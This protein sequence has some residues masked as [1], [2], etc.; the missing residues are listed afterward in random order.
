MVK[1]LESKV[2]D[3]VEDAEP[4]PKVDDKP[5]SG[6]KVAE[7]VSQQEEVSLR[8]MKVVKLPIETLVDLLVG[9]TMELVP[10]LTAM[11]ASFFLRSPDV[12]DSLQIFLQKTSL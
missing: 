9:S 1:M 8:P 7:L 10:S 11:S 12:C 5:E 3:V 6:P 2:V 4:E